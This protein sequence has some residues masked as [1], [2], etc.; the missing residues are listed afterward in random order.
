M[1]YAVEETLAGRADQLK[2]FTIAVDVFGRSLQ[3]DA[4]TDP[5]VRVE[6]RR[7]RRRLADYYAD[8]GQGD[9]IRIDLPV[10][11]YVPRFYRAEPVVAERRRLSGW[12][13]LGTLA[14]AL[15]AA[16]LVAIWQDPGSEAGRPLRS[17]DTQVER[18]RAPRIAVV[19]FTNLSD[20][21]ALDAFVGGLT[22]ETLIRLSEYGVPVVVGGDPTK[23]EAHAQV[24]AFRQ[25]GVRYILGGSVRRQDDL[26]RIAPRLVDLAT[27]Q[28]VW[29][30]SFD[31][32]LD[33]RESV[34]TQERIGT[35]I[36]AILTNPFGP[37][38]GPEMGK[39]ADLP[40]AKLDSY[41]CSVQFRAYVQALD[42][43]AHER[44]RRCFR[45]VIHERPQGAHVW[46][47]LAL[48]YQHE[49]WYGYN[50]QPDRGEALQR[51]Y[52]AAWKAVDLDDGNLL[53]QLAMASVSYSRG[54]TRTFVESAERAMQ[55]KRHQNPSAAAQIGLLMTLSGNV[56]YG[57]DLLDAAFAAEPSVPSWYRVA[58]SFNAM[59][60]GDPAQAVD[61]ALKAHTPHWFAA[62]MALAAAAGLAGRHELAAQSVERLLA[63]DPSFLYSGRQRLERWIQNPKLI[64]LLV[65]GLSKSGLDFCEACAPAG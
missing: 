50:P 19:G 36:A 30:R 3:F 26:V 42:P 53:A 17:A 27:G 22:E 12:L 37:T 21:P 65:E 54:D 35:R 38:H 47:G 49:H 41:G 62:P 20:D 33:L 40:L 29:T 9:S 45:R 44:S 28:Q 6:A 11:G 64:E 10:G 55:L 57:R 15:S 52:E 58:Q 32:T 46:A 2:G 48:V 31:E 8:E 14:A 13:P 24:P 59:L 7:L 51:A 43:A 5:L 1:R 18:E 34:S 61:W 23:S 39:F 60:R 16:V 4:S 25:A 56:H 63:T